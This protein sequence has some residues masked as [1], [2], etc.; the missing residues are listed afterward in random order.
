MFRHLVMFRFKPEVTDD[1]RAAA[2]AALQALPSRIPE[3]AGYH[4]G[5][6][7]GLRDGNFELGVAAV[8]AD[9]AAWRTYLAHPAHVAAVEGHINPNVAER[10]S[11]QYT[12]EP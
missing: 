12:V 7:L 3:I 4:V 11:I 6:D 2:L 5:V 9:E 10:A 8:F 1:Q